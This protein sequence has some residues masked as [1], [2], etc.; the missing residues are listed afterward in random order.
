MSGWGVESWGLGV[1]GQWFGFMC[2]LWGLR[3]VV[4]GV[5]FGAWGLGCGVEGFGFGV[6]GMG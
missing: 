4:Q 1:R 5:G 3:C 2:G 6:W